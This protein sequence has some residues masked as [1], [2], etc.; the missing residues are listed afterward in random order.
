MTDPRTGA[1][2]R[3]RSIDEGLFLEVGGLPQW[4]TLRDGTPAI[5]C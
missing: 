1:R 5:R 3:A 2:G 4:V